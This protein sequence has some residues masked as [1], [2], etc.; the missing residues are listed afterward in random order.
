MDLFL[1][2]LTIL[3]YVGVALGTFMIFVYVYTDHQLNHTPGG[4][5]RQ[6]MAQINGKMIGV[7]PVGK[8]VAILVVSGVWLITTYMVP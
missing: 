1:T 4:Q 8:Y 2:F 3:A 7:K 5:I 6:T